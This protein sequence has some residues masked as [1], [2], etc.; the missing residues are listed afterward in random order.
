MII[1]NP[2]LVPGCTCHDHRE[3]MSLGFTNLSLNLV[4]CCAAGGTTHTA[5]TPTA[6]I[7]LWHRRQVLTLPSLLWGGGGARRELYKCFQW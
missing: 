5:Q 3:E 7:P 1:H 2:H 4:Q 6:P